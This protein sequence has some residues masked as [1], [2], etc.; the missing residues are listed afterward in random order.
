MP[1]LLIPNTCN[2]V[3]PCVPKSQEPCCQGFPLLLPKFHTQV[4]QLCQSIW[5]I[6]HELSHTGGPMGM[7]PSPPRARGFSCFSFCCTT[8]LTAKREPVVSQSSLSQSLTASPSGMLGSSEPRVLALRPIYIVQ[9]LLSVSPHCV[10]AWYHGAHY[11]Y[12]PSGQSGKSTPRCQQQSVPSCS[13]NGNSRPVT[14]FQCCLG[15]HPCFPVFHQ[16][17]CRKNCSHTVPHAIW[18]PLA[19][20]TQWSL[21]LLYLLGILLS[22]PAVSLILLM[23]STFL[24]FTL[25]TEPRVG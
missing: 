10:P 25:F 2:P 1:I 20:S 12:S 22:T 8:G 17:A 11:Q 6:C 24:V 21:G 13:S 14:P 7:L 18:W 23:T 19:S 5:S 3:Y 16:S 4:N 15:T 9:V